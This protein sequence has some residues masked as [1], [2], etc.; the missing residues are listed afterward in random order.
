MG[1]PASTDKE[2]LWRSLLRGIYDEQQTDF[3]LREISALLEEYPSG[4][5]SRGT[6]KQTLTEQDVILITYPDQIRQTGL[7]PL[8]A[9]SDFCRKHLGEVISILHVLPFYPSSSDDGFSVTDY[10]RVDPDLGTWA[11]ISRLRAG[12]R[13]MMDAVVNH[14]SARSTWF[15]GF[16]R[17][18]EMYRGYF[19]E[20]QNSPDLVSVVRPR[21]TPLLHRFGNEPDGKTVWTTFSDDQVD[22]NYKNPRV[23]LEMI[24]LLLFYA[25]HG[26]ILIRLDAV[27][28]LWKEPGTSCINLPQTHRIIRFFRAVIEEIAP[29]VRIVTETNV[30]QADVLS[31]FGDGDNEAH[32]VYNFALPPLVLHTFLT[33]DHRRLSRWLDSLPAFGGQAAFLNFLASHDGIGLNS[34]REILP[35]DDVHRLIQATLDHGGRISDK[36][37]PDGTIEPYELNINYF[38]ALSDP[39][40]GEPLGI[41]TCRFLAAHAILL[42]LAGIPAIYF[43]SLFGSRGWGEG[44]EQTGRNRTINRRKFERADFER[45]L[46]DGSGLRSRVFSGLARLIRARMQSPAFDPY[47]IQKTVDFGSAVFGLLRI[48]PETGQRVLC[49]QE[50]SGKPQIIALD[51]EPAFGPSAPASSFFDLVSGRRFSAQDSDPF[52]LDPYQSCWLASSGGAPPL[53]KERIQ[54]A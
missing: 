14:V 1:L 44:V 24:D 53:P 2:G 47:G 20:L 13:L 49:L 5:E 4:F 38:D 7:S 17:G 9:L 31:Y 26:A 51:L 23:L 41:Q 28:Y 46:A 22:L 54:P 52:T 3:L 40:G 36:R 19:I 48:H 15:Q 10:R 33:G 34:A 8:A 35:E 18:E 39:G 12:F 32:L 45:E 21:A 30:P 42:G 6:R 50:V 27:A 43:H 16:L 25:A 37:M 11:D 29:D